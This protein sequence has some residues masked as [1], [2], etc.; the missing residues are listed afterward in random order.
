M[1]AL[2]SLGGKGDVLFGQLSCDG[3][4]AESLVDVQVEDASDDRRFG[5][6]YLGLAVV[7]DAVSVWDSVC[8]YSAL[9]GGSA[10]TEG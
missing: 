6:V 8:G 4:S 1:P 5:L 2:A 9:L 10:S 3:R 7:S